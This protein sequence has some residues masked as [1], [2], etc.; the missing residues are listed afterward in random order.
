MST[1]DRFGDNT[2]V[3]ALAMGGDPAILAALAHGPFE[4]VRDAWGAADMDL[5]WDKGDPSGSA[6]AALW[7]ICTLLDG[8]ESPEWGNAGGRYDYSPGAGGLSSD[9]WAALAAG[10]YAEHW[11]SQDSHDAHGVQALFDYLAES[12]SHLAHVV[13]LGDMLSQVIDRC[14]ALS[15]H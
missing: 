14:R 8:W 13:H 3:G 9:A 7:D 11:E 1:I 6:F 2:V 4:S 15:D 10:D 5:S 12:D